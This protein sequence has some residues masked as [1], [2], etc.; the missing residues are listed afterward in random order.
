MKEDNHQT[1]QLSEK[2]SAFELNR[3]QFLKS[4]GGGIIIF[5]SIIMPPLWQEKG[6]RVRLCYLTST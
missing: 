2:T 1:L 6:N 5:F 4:L 3:R